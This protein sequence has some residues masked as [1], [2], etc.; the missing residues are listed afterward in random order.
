MSPCLSSAKSGP[1]LTTLEDEEDDKKKSKKKDLRKRN[2]QVFSLA[3]FRDLLSSRSSFVDRGG[4]LPNE[5]LP[6]P[7]DADPEE[8]VIVVDG[9]KV[10]P[11]LF[12]KLACVNA[13]HLKSKQV[14]EGAQ[15]QLVSAPFE[16]VNEPALS[17]LL[18]LAT[19]IMTPPKQH[20]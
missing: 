2:S 1:D 10:F 14:R 16:S 19:P 7:P 3:E 18:F 13:A 8:G 11:P 6:P 12:G 9:A 5:S 20:N 15:K 17:Y 4:V